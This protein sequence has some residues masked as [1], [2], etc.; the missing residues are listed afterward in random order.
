MII[1]PKIRGFICTTSH[2]VGCAE[3]VARQVA[4]VKAQQPVEAPKRVLVIGASTG[5]GL[6][7]RIVPTFTAGAKTIGVFFEKEPAGKRTGTAGWYNT[8]A[9]EKAAHDA[10][11]YA[12]SINGD[13]FSDEIKQQTVDLIKDDL[14]QIDLLVYS[15]ASPRRIDP[16]TQH[17]Y[18]SAL[19]TTSEPFHSKSLDPMAG[20]VSTVTID[21]ATDEDIENTVRVMGGD[22][23]QLW[24]DLLA[25][26]NLL[27]PGC[28]TI[29]YSYIGPA[30]TFPIYREGTIGRAKKH[31][32][33][34]AHRLDE[35]LQAS[36]QGH[37]YVSVNK[38][39]V[40]QA[41]AA[42]PVVSLYISILFKVMKE[43]GVHEGCIEQIHRLFE[44][45]Y[46]EVPL[47]LDDAGRIR[48]D[49][50][51]MRN[52][53]QQEVAEAWERVNS[54]NINQL[55]D[56]EGYRND[57]YHLFGFAYD[58]VDY[59]ADVEPNVQI[60]SLAETADV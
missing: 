53:I 58:N 13:A 30:L 33:Q 6:A 25:K 55:A 48:I 42:I 11:F 19:K 43:K 1:Q 37:A 32:E 23:W 31:L 2:P 38:A 5:Y 50:Y 59:D 24:I 44:Q 49:D 3:A 14:G 12:K 57:F 17:V 60:P 18:N 54:D 56:L 39:L 8:V 9:F 21:P 35:Q 51:E 52:D 16:K 34:T 20:T 36:L 26:E 4:Y 46:G 27:A 15:L 29:A 40:T 45:L 41:S 47:Q 22:D 10:G 7:S 28:Q